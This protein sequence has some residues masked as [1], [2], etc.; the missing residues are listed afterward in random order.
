MRSMTAAKVVDLPDPVGPVTSTSPFL[1]PAISLRTPGSLKSSHCGGRGGMTRITMACEPRCMKTLTRKR[2]KPGALKERSE[3]PNFSRFSAAVWWLPKISLAIEAVCAGR[4]L[5]RPGTATACN[6]PINST[7]G[8]RP[9]EKIR[10][11]TLSETDSMC[12]STFRKLSWGGA[13]AGGG[14][15]KGACGVLIKG[16]PGCEAGR[17]EEDRYE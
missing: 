9:G 5:S 11:L 2:A 16:A 14:A 1:R 15:E 8:G 12:C 10:S 3:E 17:S 7:C 4:S 6:S 13:P